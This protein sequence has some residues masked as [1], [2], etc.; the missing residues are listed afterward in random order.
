M[1]QTG[2]MLNITKEERNRMIDTLYEEDEDE[3]SI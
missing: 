2:E 1:I 3:T